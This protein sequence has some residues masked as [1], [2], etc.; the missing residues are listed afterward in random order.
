MLFTTITTE[1]DYTKTMGIK[2][3]EG[4][5]FSEEFKSDSSAILVNKAAMEVMGLKEDALGTELEL[6]GNKRN[7]IGVVDDV[8]MG[9]PFQPVKPMFMILMDWGGSVSIRLKKQTT[10]RLLS[11]P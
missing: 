3:L 4:R 6:W 2:L 10:C 7:L 8:L 1:Y 11:R 5:D 9:S